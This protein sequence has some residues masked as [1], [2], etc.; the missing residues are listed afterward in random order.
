M[1]SNA[2]ELLGEKELQDHGG[3]DGLGGGGMR[4]WMLWETLAP[5]EKRKTRKQ[6]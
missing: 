3:G 6:V 1:G 4:R 2:K 5:S